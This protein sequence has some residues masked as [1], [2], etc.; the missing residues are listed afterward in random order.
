MIGTMI[1]RRSIA[2]TFE[3]MNRQDLDESISAWREDG[4]FI[5]PGEIPESGTFKEKDAVEGWF[6]N[7]FE[8]YWIIRF[9][10][11]EDTNAV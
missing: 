7:I 1:A 8:K 9:N 4:V 2:A 11:E 10:A 5:Y 6:Q 3:A